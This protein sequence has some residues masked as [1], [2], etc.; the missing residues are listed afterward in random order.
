MGLNKWLK[1][2]DDE[3]KTKKIKKSPVKAKKSRIDNSQ[4]EAVEKKSIK[5][6]KYT[7]ICP[8]VKCKY[9]KTIMKKVITDNDKTCPRC[10]KK[11]K[12]KE[13]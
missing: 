10:N 2:Q 8:N 11:M 12:I 5:L 7:L 6:I 4:K 1:Q 13:I 3:N 9:Q